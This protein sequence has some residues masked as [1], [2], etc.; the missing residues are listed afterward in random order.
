MPKHFSKTRGMVR[1]TFGISQFGANAVGADETGYTLSP[2][3]Y[4]EMIDTLRR[5]QRRPVPYTRHDRKRPIF[6]PGAGSRV[7]QCV[8]GTRLRAGT[9]G[10]E[11]DTSIFEPVCICVFLGNISDDAIEQASNFTLFGV[12]QIVAQFGII[13]PDNRINQDAFDQLKQA[14]EILDLTDGEGLTMLRTRFCQ[15][16][17]GTGMIVVGNDTEAWSSVGNQMYEATLQE[18]WAGGTTKAAAQI[19]FNQGAINSAASPVTSAQAIADKIAVKVPNGATVA[20]SSGDLA[21]FEYNQQ[22][23][24]F[25]DDAYANTFWYSHA[26]Y[27]WLPVF[28]L[29]AFPAPNC[30]A[31]FSAVAVAGSSATATIYTGPIGGESATS[32]TVVAYI[33]SGLVVPNKTYILEFTAGGWEVI[34]PSLIAFAQFAAVQVNGNSATATIYKGTIGSESTGSVTVSAYIRSGAVVTAKTYMLGFTSGGWEVLD[35]D[36][37]IFC[38]FAAS[39]S[40]KAF[41][42]GA[43]A[44]A[45]IYTGTVGSETT[46]GVTVS[47]Y[48][49]KGVC[50]ASG[51]DPLDALAS[52]YTLVWG[53]IGWE[54]SDP[55]LSFFGKLSGS[56]PVFGPSTSTFVIYTGTIDSEITTS[57]SVTANIRPGICLPSTTYLICESN[58]K[59]E[60]E[61]VNPDYEC[62]G[63][64]SADVASDASNGTF[65]VYTGTGAG[66]ASATTI[67]GVR[68]DTSCTIKT[69][70]IAGIKYRR[71]G[72]IWV[73]DYFHNS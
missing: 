51:N 23:W 4:R 38:Q 26:T 18:T 44:T 72:P 43:S 10:H 65:T 60:F 48:I 45:T 71:A 33:R 53:P 34:D 37:T 22:V 21:L 56:D 62:F 15:G 58:G 5:D 3:V 55:E 41:L 54:V 19:V 40:N 63:Q 2:A 12:S 31:Q 46:S 27:G 28:N 39:G 57:V 68:N 42:S 30:F 11:D 9:V 49:R 50:I 7:Y 67:T 47:A 6:Q 36:L 16:Y 25:D 69:G 66:S 14:P 52:M 8:A 20:M 59:R 35:P 24:F 29:V 73:Y 1:S 61:V 17:V 70:K 64:V 13:Q 32:K